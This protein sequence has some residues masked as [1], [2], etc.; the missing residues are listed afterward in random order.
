MVVVWCGQMQAVA[1][2]R[3][4]L[5]IRQFCNPGS[6]LMPQPAL[7][8]SAFEDPQRL[9]EVGSRGEWGRRDD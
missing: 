5:Q 4:A 9:R 6:H 8:T 7:R 1:A 2:V 3:Q